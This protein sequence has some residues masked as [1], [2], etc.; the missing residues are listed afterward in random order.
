MEQKWPVD[1]SSI[2]SNK[3]DK[4]ANIE[5]IYPRMQYALDKIKFCHEFSKI[6]RDPECLCIH[7]VT[8]VGKTF[9][10]DYYMNRY[11]PELTD[12][13][14]VKRVICTTVPEEPAKKSFATQILADLG[15]LN[16]FK[17]YS[18]TD[19]TIRVQSLIRGCK[20]ETM[21][22]DEAQHFM[23][24]PYEKPGNV[25]N[26]FKNL[27]SAT[28]I[29]IVMLGLSSCLG[30]FS[31]NEQLG[32]R[33]SNRYALTPF[34]WDTDAEKVEFRT[35]LQS[36]ETLLPFEK[37]SGFNGD[38][39]SG[40]IY[41]AT[42]G[43]MDYVIKLITLAGLIAL[44]KNEPSITREALATSFQ[45]KLWSSRP[46][47]KENPFSPVTFNIE[48][49]YN[50]EISKATEEKITEHEKPQVERRR[51]RKKRESSQLI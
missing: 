11:P 37:E 38:D 27:I 32:R 41:Y 3:L 7:G 47:I 10:K 42:L 6:Q 22:C 26:W 23:E 31:A 35:L 30:L 29:S 20:V 46:H 9:I 33:F 43:V 28:R 39:F 19:I 36:I 25:A 2:D 13:G 49:A 24:S 21:F 5:I 45:D 14:L 16:A 44:N 12:N 40:R 51:G 34:K 1:V 4:I 15:D 50:Q 17:G 18:K 8:G 48:L